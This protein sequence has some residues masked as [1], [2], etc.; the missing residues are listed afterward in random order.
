MA[1]L[2]FND[3]VYTFDAQDGSEPIECK[4][5]LEK[6]KANEKHPDGKPHILLPKGNITNRRYFSLDLFNEKAIN[7]EVEVAIK[8]EGPRILGASGVK[9]AVLKYL[10]EA[11][12]EEY[13]TL[14]NKALEDYKAVKGTKKTIRPEDMNA[15]QLEAYIEALKSGKKVT[16][17]TGPKSF[18]D[19]FNDVEYT[20]YNEILSLAAENKANA[21]KAVRGPLTPEE[22]QARD[23]KRVTNKIS[24]AEALL[25]ALK[26]GKI[27]EE[28]EET[29]DNSED[30][31][32]DDIIEE[33]D[34]E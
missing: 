25:N 32:N 4:V 6:A 20:R 14:V 26:V 17:T 31:D 27:V 22:K 23:I 13:T 10:D 19:M 3:G 11:T 29:E 1:K 12:A 18:L 34:E 30:F 33:D 2:V 21:P 24:K 15:E 8:T 28:T 9:Q 5:W 7:G 16:A